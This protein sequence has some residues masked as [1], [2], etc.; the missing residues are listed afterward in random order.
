M[1]EGKKNARNRRAWIVFEDESGVTDRPPI[2]RTWAPRGQ[3]PVVNHPYRWRKYSV[4]GALAYRWDGKRCRF[5][6]QT[7]SGDYNS[8]SLIRFL[9]V[10]KR[11]FRGKRII[12]VWDRLNA[13]RSVAM[14]KYLALQRHWLQ[15]EWLPAYAPEL[16][17]VELVWGNVDG[18]ELANLSI[19]D[20]RDVIMALR[21]GLTRARANSHNLGLSFLRHVGLLL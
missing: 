2:R 15:V 20:S 13:H 17:P 1:A 6:F 11:H 9:R 21:R 8:K 7:K 19:E 3:T 16:N 14:R 4:A 10:L 12:L 18:N 5:Y